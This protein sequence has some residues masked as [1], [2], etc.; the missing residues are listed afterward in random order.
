M[1]ACSA[2]GADREVAVIDPVEFQAMA[3]AD[4]A[5]VILDVR[6]PEEFE[7]G[8]IKGAQLL[9][10]LDTEVFKQDAESL[11]SAK[12]IYIYCRSGRRSNEAACYLA[13]KGFRV[14]DLAGGIM[15]WE[16]CGLPIVK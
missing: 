3:S 11:D 7:A 16:E 6:T 8:H 5:A 2:N 9:N 13:E 4:T 10:W 15:R 1:A 14:V 12:T